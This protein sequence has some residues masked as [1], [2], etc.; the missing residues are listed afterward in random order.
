MDTIPIL[1]IIGGVT[2]M[3]LL[4]L[5]SKHKTPVLGIVVSAIIFTLIVSEKSLVRFLYAHDLERIMEQRE[6]M[7]EQRE[8]IDP[9]KYQIQYDELSKEFDY[10]IQQVLDIKMAIG[11]TSVVLFVI[12]MASML[13]TVIKHREKVFV[14]TGFR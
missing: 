14:Y 9:E 6:R 7:M 4:W 10:L 1:I 11:Y 3:L 13:I 12:G 5:S 2:Y 8:N